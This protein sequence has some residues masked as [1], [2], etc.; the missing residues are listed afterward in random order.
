VIRKITVTMAEETA[1]RD[2]L[3]L[4]ESFPADKTVDRVK[5]GLASLLGK[6]DKIR[7]CADV[8][9]RG[10]ALSAV[11]DTLKSLGGK[12]YAPWAGGNAAVVMNRMKSMK[13]TLDQIRTVARWLG[14]QSW[15][16][17]P[18]TIG[19]LL[20]KWD[21]YIAKSTKWAESEASGLNEHTPKLGGPVGFE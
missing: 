2:A 18:F 9:E 20:N 12:N 14:A 5:R 19:Q 10:L 16:R 7:D 11:D 6:V 3:A 13:L 17:S 15:I 8:Q 1:L 4:L 21:E